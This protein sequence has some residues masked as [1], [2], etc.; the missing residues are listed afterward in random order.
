VE[1]PGAQSGEEEAEAPATSGSQ[2]VPRDGTADAESIVFDHVTIH[3]PD[4]R[5]LVKDINLL[6]RPGENLLVT[7]EPSHLPL[8][9]DLVGFGRRNLGGQT[10]TVSFMVFCTTTGDAFSPPAPLIEAGATSRL[11]SL[12]RPTPAT[13]GG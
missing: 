1:A 8:S 12:C 3:A 6:I 11:V 10:S 9:R 7:G 4:G 5:L 2:S 13:P